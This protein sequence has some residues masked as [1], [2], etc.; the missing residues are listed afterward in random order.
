MIFPAFFLWFAI[1]IPG[2]ESYMAGSPR[3]MTADLSYHAGRF[4]GMDL[5]ASGNAI[6]VAGTKVAFGVG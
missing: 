4:L 5:A 2:I 3:V 1:P 6:E